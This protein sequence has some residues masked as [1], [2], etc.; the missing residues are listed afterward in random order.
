MN[1]AGWIKTYRKLL[2]WEHYRNG[3]VVRLFLHLLLMANVEDKEWKGVTIKRGQLVTSVSK[4][5]NE[6]GLTIN[7]IRTSKTTLKNSGEITVKTTNKFS[8]I[9]ICKFES[10]QDCEKVQSQAKSQAKPQATTHPKPQQLKNNKEDKNKSTNVDIPLYPPGLEPKASKK[11]SFVVAPEFEEA[12][13]TWLE[14]KHQRR[15]SYKTPKSLEACYKKLLKL[16]NNDPATAMAIVEQSLAN[17][18][19]GLF[20]LKPDYATTTNNQPTG[21]PRAAERAHLANG[22]AAAIARL[23]AEDDARAAGVR[24]P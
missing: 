19:A 12:F 24:R 3:N 22:Y 11:Y 21:D 4:L 1:T 5:A 8:V 7:Q 15:Q 20:P 2:E 14:Y 10:Y 18:W 6:L 17:N 9:T 13:S 23:A 16:A